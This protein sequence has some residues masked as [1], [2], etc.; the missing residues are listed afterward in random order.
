[1]NPVRTVSATKAAFF[2]AYARPINSVYRRV[3]EEL[4]VE[5]HLVTVNAQ[6]VYDPFFALGLV[7]VY[8]AL[9]EGYQPSDQRDP[10]YQALC[11]SLQ[12][13]PEV[14]R[15]DAQTLLD[16]LRSAD[17]Q[18][19]LSLLTLRNDAMDVGG[20]R[21]ILE[22]MRSGS[23]AYSRIL[24]IGL[25]T[26]YDLLQ[27]ALNRESESRLEP[28]VTEMAIPL[29][30]S[31]ERVKRDLELYRNSLERMKQARAVVE[32]MVKAARR[33]QER[34]QTV[35]AQPEGGKAQA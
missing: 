31:G 5:L 18:Q 20:I 19:R 33:Q 35:L 25:F 32:E 17:P 8:D 13:K 6:F 12:L 7:T 34:R 14:L 4:L 21:S 1:M 15:Q 27:Q 24:G 9:M 2:G 10:I 22:R 16:L 26:C 23:Y 30:F 11:K 3:I 28:F 29:G